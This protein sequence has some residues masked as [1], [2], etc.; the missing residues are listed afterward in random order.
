M[1]QDGS[2]DNKIFAI[3]ELLDSGCYC[4]NGCDA[5]DCLMSIYFGIQTFNRSI[6]AKKVVFNMVFTKANL[7]CMPNYM[8][9][10]EFKHQVITVFVRSQKC[11][12]ESVCMHMCVCH[13]SVCMHVCTCV[14]QGCV[15]VC[16][17]R[18]CVCVC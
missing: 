2:E 15:C 5:G 16:V 8:S 3:Y 17:L 10:R 1:H 9:S 14:C 18:V 12:I 7:L 11:L 4:D 6:L 13:A